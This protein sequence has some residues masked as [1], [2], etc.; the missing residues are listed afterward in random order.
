M[1][2]EIGLTL[3]ELADGVT[4]KDLMSTTACSFKVK[5]IIEITSMK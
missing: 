4:I 3:I 2:K 5:S 1:D